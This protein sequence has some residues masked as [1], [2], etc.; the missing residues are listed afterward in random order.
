MFEKALSNLGKMPRL[1]IMYL[2]F[3]IEN[4]RITRTRLT[5]NSALRALPITQHER[6]W[7]IVINRFIGSEDFKVPVTTSKRLLERYLQFEPEYADSVIS[8]LIEKGDILSAVE[9]LIKRAEEPRADSSAKLLLLIELISK[10]SNKL[11]SL[12]HVN[13]PAIIRTGI[14]RY[15][16]K[17]GDLW[18]ALSDYY[19]RLGLFSK[20][21][22]VYEEAMDS[23]MTVVDFSVIF[24]A[25]QNFLQLVV[26]TKFG[27]GN[28]SDAEID[29]QRLELLIERR[30]D[31][32]SSVVLRQNPDNVI[33]WTKRAKLA[34]IVEGGPDRIISVFLKA[35]QTVNASSPRLVGR[36]SS[37]WIEFA[38]FH[39]S[40]GDLDSARS[41]FE[42]AVGSNFKTVEDLAS[43]W[44]E[45]ILM[46]LRLAVSSDHNCDRVLDIARRAVSQY[47]GAAKGTVQSGLFRS[48]KLWALA[49]DVEESVNGE[50][51]PVLVRAMYDSMM[52]LKVITPQCVLN[53]AQFELD[54]KLFEKSIQVLEKA[55]SI[56]SW[57]HCRDIWLFYISLVQRER[58]RFSTERVRDM[59]EQV[60]HNCDSKFSSLFYFCAFKF[61]LDRG[62]ASDAIR[63]LRRAASQV[64][65]DAKAGFFL[66]AV[67]QSMQT[68]GAAPTRGLFEEAIAALAS[69]RDKETIE[70]CVEYCWME[71][72]LGQT[73]RARKLLEHASQFANPNKEEL[74]FFWDVWKNFEIQH[75]SEDTFKEMKRMQRSILVRFSDKHFNTLDVGVADAAPVV[76]AAEAKAS[77]SGIDLSKLKQMAALKKAAEK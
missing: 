77:P 52:E 36:M 29:L 13:L 62:L 22:D 39:T 14:D 32:L 49:L 51:K 24:E 16:S 19:I 2:E 8:F 63:I 44:I 70:M 18:N 45:Y 9:L 71:A 27:A 1:W 57:P 75:G 64:P 37:L 67:S 4:R 69:K 68:Q 40:Q 47:R 60:L 21:V 53:Y 11:K 58:K 20:A 59:F 72:A 42:R 3:L 50:S 55:L 25:Y 12:E 41:V 31:L 30:A 54:R 61:E 48:V 33:E 76:V 73:S 74:E 6:I 34:R 65:Y 38:K 5:I 15:P 23:V 46:E 43:V 28:A 56:F 10:N 26:E 7:D 17:L 66:M 35:I